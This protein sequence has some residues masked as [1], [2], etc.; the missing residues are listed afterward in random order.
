[1]WDKNVRKFAASKAGNLTLSEDELC[2]CG[3][4]G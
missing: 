1:M 2:W 4:L 3:L